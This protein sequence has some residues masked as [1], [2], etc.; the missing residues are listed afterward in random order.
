[1]FEKLSTEYQLGYCT[2]SQLQR[3]VLVN[4]KKPGKGIT[5][6]EYQEITGEACPV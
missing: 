3:Y 4:D 2:K 5:R 6:D 1:M